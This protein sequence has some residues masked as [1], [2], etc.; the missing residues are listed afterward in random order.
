METF[1]SRPVLSFCVIHHPK[2]VQLFIKDSAVPRSHTIPLQ[3]LQVYAHPQGVIRGSY[4]I[5][6]LKMNLER[7]SKLGRKCGGGKYKG[8][9]RSAK[10]T[11]SG[12]VDRGICGVGGRLGPSRRANSVMNCIDSLRWEVI[13]QQKDRHITVKLDDECV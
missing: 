8:G 6:Y 2:P 11:I 9:P 5:L 3:Y 10:E 1:K 12:R 13:L 7:I 4:I